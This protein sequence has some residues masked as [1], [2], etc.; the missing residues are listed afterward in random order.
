[1][2]IMTVPT[3]TIHH[4]A[5]LSMGLLVRVVWAQTSNISIYAFKQYNVS[6]N[7]LATSPLAG[8]RLLACMAGLW[9]RQASFLN[10]QD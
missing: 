9:E 2:H 4:A 5:T 10:I 7:A 8:R 6:A 1:M 3:L